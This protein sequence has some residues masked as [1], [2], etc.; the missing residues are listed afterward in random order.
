MEP[1]TVSFAVTRD[2]FLD[3]RTAQMK[4]AMTHAYRLGVRLT[5]AYLLIFSAVEIALCVARGWPGRWPAAVAA[6]GGI[7]LLFL[8]NPTLFTLTRMR[9]A[10]DFDSG[11]TAPASQTVRL[12]PDR[13]EI[14][15]ERYEAELPYSMLFCVFEDGGVFLLYTGGGECRCIPKRAMAPGDCETAEA[16]FADRLKQKFIQEGAREWTR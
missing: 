12:F 3:C 1:V 14:R 8:L 10:E 6:A 11:R 15:S 16:L 13:I 4:R 2:D 5:G 9:A 7:F